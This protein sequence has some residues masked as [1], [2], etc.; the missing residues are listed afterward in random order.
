MKNIIEYSDLIEKEMAKYK[1]EAGKVIKKIEKRF[2]KGNMVATHHFKNAN[3][4]LIR[5][6][7]SELENAG[8]S[9]EFIGNTPTGHI[10]LRVS[11]LRSSVIVA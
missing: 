7:K 2:N 11:L 6:M 9:P 10:A 1:K 4:E 5:M 3:P 8:Y